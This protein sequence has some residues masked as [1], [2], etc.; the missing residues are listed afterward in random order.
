[1][2]IEVQILNGLVSEFNRRVHE[3]GFTRIKKCL[4]LLSEEEVWLRPNKNTV[5]VGNLIL[6]LSGN[7]EQWIGAGLGDIPDTRK[8]DVE[9]ST[10]DGL[11]K[12]E[13]IDIIQ[14]TILDAQNVL[15][16]TSAED[17]I[18][19]KEVQVYKES[20]LSIIVHVIEHFSYH[21]GQITYATKSIKDVDTLY[22]PEDL[23]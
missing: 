11:S 18:L 13:L 14:K 16:A 10:Q 23:G 2:K 3:E 15:S 19:E 17:L 1:M 5:S 8:R 6:H 12:G 20:G 21:I 9:F 7:V 4:S 22:Y